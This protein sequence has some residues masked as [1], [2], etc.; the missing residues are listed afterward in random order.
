MCVL[1]GGGNSVHLCNTAVSILFMMRCDDYTVI[2]FRYILGFLLLCDQL[3]DVVNICIHCCVCLSFCK[4][5]PLLEF[6]IASINR[7]KVICLTDRQALRIQ[8]ACLV[9]LNRKS[10]M[11]KCFFDLRLGTVQQ[12]VPSKGP[13]WPVLKPTFSQSETCED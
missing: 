3:V 10:R 11:K 12:A 9:C 4:I 13:L 7:K 2:D 1:G 8:S 5:M 6:E